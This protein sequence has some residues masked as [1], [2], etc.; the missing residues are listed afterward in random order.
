MQ[1]DISDTS[2]M[3]GLR[4]VAVIGVV[5]HHWL[6]FVP[7]VD[8]RQI[9]GS[10]AGFVQDVGGTTVQLFFV[11]SGCGLA[12]SYLKAREPFFLGQWI[13]RRFRKVVL[14]YWIIVAG[15]FALANMASLG[16]DNQAGSY[17]WVSFL[18]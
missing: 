10:I 7:F 4:A 5:I 15:T 16:S 3:N 17:S 6:L 1:R 8:T 13:R 14:P 2:W 18:A 11:L 12:V 9:S